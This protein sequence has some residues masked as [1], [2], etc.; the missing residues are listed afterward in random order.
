MAMTDELK[1]D[2]LDAAIEGILSRGQAASSGDE[3]IDAL[4]RV[5]SG[6]RGLPNPDF[7]AR[8]RAELL[9]D[10][11]QRPSLLKSIPGASWFKAQHAFLGSGAS[12]GVVAGACCISG[13]AAHVLG[14][15]SAS[16]VQE[17]IQSSLPYFVALSIIGLVGWLLWFLREQGITLATI[18]LTARR[19]GFALAGS[20]GLVFAASMSLTMAMGLY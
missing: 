18:G 13:A 15:A 11:R 8:L 12:S 19:H 1:Y 17:F 5:A 3:G 20:Y 10:S 6:L 9:T 2:G 4:T 14:L 16:T 7:K